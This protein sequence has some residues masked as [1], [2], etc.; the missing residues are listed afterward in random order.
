MSELWEILVPQAFNDGIK[1]PVGH[2]HL[3]D[4]K[5]RGIAG[6][7]TVLRTARGIWQSPTGEIFR[8]K[9][10]PVRIACSKTQIL[11]IM[12]FTKTH[13]LQEKVMAYRISDHVIIE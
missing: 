4:E 12:A 6:G 13:Y 1:V 10:I 5:V 8:E 11:E 3:W 9:M 7:L 2:H